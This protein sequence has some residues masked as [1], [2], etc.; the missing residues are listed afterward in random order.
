[1]SSYEDP[2]SQSLIEMFCLCSVDLHI[3]NTTASSGFYRLD[4]HGISRDDVI[5]GRILG[6]GFFGE[7]HE[8]VYK[9][10]VSSYS[11]KTSQK[12]K[13]SE[14]IKVHP[15]KTCYSHNTKATIHQQLPERR[16]CGCLLIWEGSKVIY[17]LVSIIP[18]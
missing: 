1:M 10:P 16:N 13:S 5:V 14:E 3:C 6:E 15:V 9:S 17:N 2:G 4:K 7:V 8:G 11:F 18:Q 12:L